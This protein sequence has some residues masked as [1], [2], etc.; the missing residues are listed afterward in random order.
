MGHNLSGGTQRS[1]AAEGLRNVHPAV[2]DA[3]EHIGQS[4]PSFTPQLHPAQQPAFSCLTQV[5]HY[6]IPFSAQFLL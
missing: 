3:V 6:H 4:A 5:T 1:D 2:K